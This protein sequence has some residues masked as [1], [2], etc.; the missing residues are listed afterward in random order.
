MFFSNLLAVIVIIMIMFA[1]IWFFTMPGIYQKRAEEKERIANSLFNPHSGSLTI[2]AINYFFEGDKKITEE[3]I[4]RNVSYAQLELYPTIGCE[5]PTLF[6]LEE[7]E[8]TIKKI[9]VSKAEL[10]K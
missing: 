4:I 8:K 2:K 1:A 7:G 9:V 3:I 5:K 6:Y 10:V